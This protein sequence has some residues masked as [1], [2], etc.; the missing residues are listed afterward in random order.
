M[1]GQSPGNWAFFLAKKYKG[2]TFYLLERPCPCLPATF[3]VEKVRWLL[4]TVPI[5]GPH[6]TIILGAQYC[7][8]LTQMLHNC[9]THHSTH[10]G[11]LSWPRAGLFPMH[12]VLPLIMHTHMFVRIIHR[13]IISIIISMVCIHYTHVQCA[14]LFFPQKFGQKKCTL[15]MAQYS[16]THVHKP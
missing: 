7:L 13:L 11:C 15:Y 2:F 4:M 6:K 14:S 12:C 3:L 9:T 16:T 10:S 5:E 8:M 1:L